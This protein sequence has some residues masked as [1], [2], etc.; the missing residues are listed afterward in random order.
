[1]KIPPAPIRYSDPDPVPAKPKPPNLAQALTDL[2]RRAADVLDLI[3]ASVG[4]N[5]STHRDHAGLCVVE[6]AVGDLI[7]ALRGRRT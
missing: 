2:D 6:T 4:R 7:A 5:L 3:Q 1:M